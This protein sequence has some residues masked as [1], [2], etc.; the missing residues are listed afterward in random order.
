MM[1]IEELEQ[2]LNEIRVT[3]YYTLR[4]NVI[5]Y[6]LNYKNSRVRERNNEFKSGWTDNMQL[7]NLEGC[8]EDFTDDETLETFEILRRNDKRDLLQMFNDDPEIML[9]Y[10]EEF[11][12]Y[13][14]ATLKVDPNFILKILQREK[15]TQMSD[16]DYPTN[17]L[18]KK[19]IPWI[20][21]IK[22]TN[23]PAFNE[24]NS[25]CINNK[26]S[27]FN[28]LPEDLKFEII[29]TATPE[30]INAIITFQEVVDLEYFINF[31]KIIP[32]NTLRQTILN[33]I[34][35]IKHLPANHQLLNDRELCLIVVSTNGL[36]IEYFSSELKDDRDIAIQ[37]V[38]SDGDA[39]QFIN[40]ALQNDFEII[41]EAVFNVT[42]NGE[43]KNTNCIQ[44]V[45]DEGSKKYINAL[46]KVQRILPYL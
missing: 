33:N 24:I 14:S 42:G 36:L 43:I 13:F 34:Y 1:T 12:E 21:R 40:T 27:Y 39:I 23:E 30:I 18:N 20:L 28:N 8:F 25:Y 19:I 3:T 16:D 5:D 38:K 6:L 29:G 31:I 9:M 2:K 17:W 35:D 44:W 11:F 41:R 15:C 4:E 46:V 32:I 7:V 37:A 45:T 26:I 22:E 10:G